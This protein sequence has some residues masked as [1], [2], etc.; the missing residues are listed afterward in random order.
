MELPACVFTREES[1]A[2]AVSAEDIIGEVLLGAVDELDLPDRLHEAAER[3]YER[4]GEWLT[5]RLSA[6]A[7]WHVYPQGSMRL[8]TVVRPSPADQYDLDLVAE[9]QVAK[10]SVTKRELK[11]TVGGALTG[12][13]DA[14]AGEPGAP[15]SLKP[16]RRCWTMAFREPFHMDV[17]PA[18]PNPDQR[19]DGI[20]ITDRDLVAW[21]P[22]NPIGFAD[23][24]YARMGPEL[25]KA[26]LELASRYQVDVDDLPD[27]R[28]RRTTLQRVVQVLKVHRNQFFAGR[29]DDRPPSIIV[30]TLAAHAYR[31]DK[32]LIEAVMEAAEGMPKHV[33][34]D[35]NRYTVCN[36]V[37][38]DENFADR[39]VAEPHRA[40]LFFRWVDD[41]QRSLDVAR[42]SKG[43]LD[44]VG[45]RLQESFGAEVIA[46]SLARYGQRHTDD[47]VAGRLTVGA[48]G[49]L[50]A[51]TLPV[52][53]HM[54]HG[55]EPAKKFSVLREGLYERSPESRHRVAEKVA[56]LTEELGLADLRALMDRTQ[57]QLAQLIGTSQSGVSRIERQQD[58][59]VSTLRDYV[60][61]TGGRLRVLA[62]YA[63][64]TCEL[65]LPVLAS[66]QI[67]HQP[68][69]FRV[70][71]QN[72]R[73][74]QL[75]HVGQLKFT[76][77]R[78]VFSYAPDAELD[79][80]FQPFPTFGNL[81]KSY[82]SEKLFPFFAD[83]IASSAL[84]DYESRLAALGLTREEATPI[85]LLA[86]SW[87]AMA[88]DTIQVVPEP[89][90]V[91]D[92]TEVLPFLVSGVR[93]AD[94]EDPARVAML[95]S[96]LQNG[97]ELALRD[98]PDN[99]V[100]S[101]AIILESGGDPVGWVP[102]YLLDYVHKRREEGRTTR[103]LVEHAN[104]D[105]TAWHLRLLC[106][107]EVG[108]RE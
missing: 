51:G 49:A 59:L 16:R 87:G 31:G 82:E 42:A 50:G 55:E 78:Y 7:D 12:F 30:T 97:D 28:A 80:D 74:R 95:V 14:H 47:R 34:R 64:F 83:R 53:D 63:D 5:G 17:M 6:T 43:G 85:E 92:G 66:L 61:A 10:E 48:T 69:E 29:L 96:R 101:R 91:G 67:P 107:L 79:P 71:W 2:M 37:Q 41:L 102:D 84:D 24:F 99:P 89:V 9:W 46:K 22:S 56:Q 35:G 27:W 33:G 45:A 26:K 73:T 75:V 94:E 39:W 68:R 11:D 1:V 20:Q 60:A 62:E 70:V 23:W 52:R 40:T 13:L 36:P 104:G 15:T 57:A 98:E 81:A 106:R 86:R 58:I 72:V 44:V 38:P 54:F 108:P 100:N 88:Y 103:V 93:H 76:G 90:A 3:T 4:V 32:P 8:G 65:S 19:P 25:K 18:I 77:D 105:G 21:L